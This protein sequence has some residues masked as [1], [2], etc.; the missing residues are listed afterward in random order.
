MFLCR[1]VLTKE[2][3]KEILET[4]KTA[5][6]NEGETASTKEHKDNFEVLEKDLALSV[7]NKIMNHPSLRNGTFISEMTLPLFNKYKNNGHYNKHID[8]FRQANVRTDFSMTLFLTEPNTY[9]GGELVIEDVAHEPLKFKLDAGDMIVYPSGKPHYVTD[10]TEGERIAA[11]AWAESLVEDGA[12]RK[13]LEKLVEIMRFVE[14]TDNK[15]ILTNCSYIYNN[16]L[17][18]WSK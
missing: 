12:D 15:E 6:W 16:L 4:L 9:K 8:S 13:I 2:E 3:V 17:R 7:A 5:K 11:I 1:E 14:T 10:V 18:K